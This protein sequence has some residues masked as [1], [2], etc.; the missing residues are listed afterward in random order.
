MENGTRGLLLY[1]QLTN[2]TFFGNATRIV[3]ALMALLG[4]AASIL[5]IGSCGVYQ[6][7][8]HSALDEPQ[9]VDSWRT[10]YVGVFRLS[11]VKNG[12]PSDQCI[13]F[14]TLADMSGWDDVVNNPLLLSAQ[15][16]AILSPCIAA[17]A[18]FL[19]LP[20]CCRVP[21]WMVALLYLVAVAGQFC[22]MI[23]LELVE[24]WC[25]LPVDLPQ[26][27]AFFPFVGVEKKANIDSF[28]IPS[29]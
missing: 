8:Y 7:S 4:I 22:I 23:F 29:Q 5:V 1:F 28:F 21:L 13:P 15:W 19:L 18:T 25:V 2:R 26:S 16:V 12:A 10:I 17:L 3:T 9:R 27:V 6:T 24:F 20:L 11:T 14:S